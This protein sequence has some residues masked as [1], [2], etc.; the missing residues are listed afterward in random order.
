MN[1]VTDPVKLQV[2]VPW[3]HE[4]LTIFNDIVWSP[5]AYSKLSKAIESLQ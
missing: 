2:L 5:K 1:S 4:I 3:S